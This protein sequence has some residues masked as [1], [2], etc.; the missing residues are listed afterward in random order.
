M[1]ICEMID[2]VCNIART[3]AAIISAL[4]AVLSRKNSKK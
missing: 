2:M 1:N 4:C 3:L